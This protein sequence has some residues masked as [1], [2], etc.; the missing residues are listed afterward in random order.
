V[1]KEEKMAAILF[2]PILRRTGGY[3]YDSYTPERGLKSGPAY[4]RIED[5][6]YA[7]RA[8]AASGLVC[9]TVDEFLMRRS[10]PTGLAV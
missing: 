1:T 4:R 3:G 10:Q 5:A 8:E 2:G 9:R 7:Q 6:L